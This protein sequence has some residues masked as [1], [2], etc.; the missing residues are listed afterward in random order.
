[1][2]SRKETKLKH[3]YVMLLDDDELDNY[4]N[5]KM[6][7]ATG[8][9]ER[10][11]V[12]SSG[13]SAMEFLNNLK[14]SYEQFDLVFPEVIFID[15]N[16]PI[17]DGFQ[18][19]ELFLTTHGKNLKSTQLVILTSSVFPEDK[20]KAKEI[21]DNIIFLNKPLTEEMLNGLSFSL[22]TNYI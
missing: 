2:I 19:L 22:N 11:Y 21:S 17:M 16:M 10:T 6:I 15:I 9:S 4:I 12:T 20:N 13:K 3:K 5:E 14:L 18:F 7:Q 1:M 8:F